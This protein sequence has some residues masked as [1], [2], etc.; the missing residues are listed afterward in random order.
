MRLFESDGSDDECDGIDFGE[1]EFEGVVFGVIGYD[2]E[3]IFLRAWFDS[4]EDG[5][6]RCV[7]DVGAVPLKEE[8]G[9]GYALA[10]YDVTGE[11]GG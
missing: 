8:R 2:S 5:S 9:H 1:R 6:L 3:A 4:F 11:I 7:E 10:C